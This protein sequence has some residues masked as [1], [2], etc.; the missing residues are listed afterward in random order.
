MQE[1]MNSVNDSGYFQDVESNY[2]GR[3]SVLALCSAATKDCRLTHGINL[4][5]R[6]TFLEINS[7]RL[8]HP[9]II[10]KEFNLTTC[11]ETEKQSLKQSNK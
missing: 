5:D 7:L 3:L 2:S 11:K 8:I 1:Q 4:D 9:E 6:K 10:L